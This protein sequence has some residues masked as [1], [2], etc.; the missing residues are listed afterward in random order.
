[1]KG[2]KGFDKDLK[3]RDYQYETGKEYEQ[4]GRPRCCDNGFHFCENPFDV[5]GYYSLDGQNRFCEVEATGEIHTQ[6]DSDDTK[7][8]TSKIKIGA[9]IGIKGLIDGFINFV[10]EKTKSSKDTTATTGNR[11][12]AATTGE[13]ANAAT[14]GNWANA[15]T[16]GN[17][18]NAA[19]TGN[20]ANAATTG[21]SANAATTG[22]WA[23]AAT[24]GESANAATTGYRANAA[25]TGNRANAEV[26]GK[27]SI[28][29]AL[30]VEGKAKGALGCWIVIAEWFQDKEGKYHIKE[31]KTAMVDGVNIKAD[32]W[33]SLTDGSIQE[34]S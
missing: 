21:E 32:T 34:Q 7:V 26:K 6:P 3:C 1:M 5:F 4:P 12:N 2:Y 14:T 22:N 8:A 15:A 11:A 18:A 16:T 30:G 20:R 9:E 24:T 17:W 23:N 33:Y 19:T 10:F 13:S 31:V 27:D 28:A 29:A 25:T